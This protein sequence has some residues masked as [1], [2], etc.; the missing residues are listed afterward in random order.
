MCN[1]IEPH[2]STFLGWG[3]SQKMWTGKSLRRWA[4]ALEDSLGDRLDLPEEQHDRTRLQKFCEH[5]SDEKCFL[6]IMAWGGMREKNAKSAWSCKDAWLP[7][8]LKMR[9]GKTS[10]QECY[11]DF[12]SLRRAGDLRGIRP[13]FFTKLIHFTRH[14]DDGY[15]MDQWTG[16]SVNLL[17]GR[18]VVDLD[19]D[20]YVTDQNSPESYEA[21]CATV[22]ALSVLCNL[23][24]S[25]T[26][27]RLFS[28]GGRDPGVWRAH[29]R[30]HWKHQRRI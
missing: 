16:K 12:A 19:R 6:S 29:V 15:I 27:E 11:H 28:I 9:Q 1:F 8:V 5:A 13:A 3:N 18:A 14:S 20:G 24:A 10:R 17:T 4:N 22:E 2:L 26:E 7:I 23:P 21:F 30:R 25:V